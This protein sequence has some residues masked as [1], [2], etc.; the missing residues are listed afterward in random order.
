MFKR[1]QK[2]ITNKRQTPRN[3]SRYLSKNST[4]ATR[5]TTKRSVSPDAA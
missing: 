5:T 2:K 3:G 1:K 4:A